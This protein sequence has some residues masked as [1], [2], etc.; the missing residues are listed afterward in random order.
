ME[1]EEIG[2]D[3]DVH[4]ICQKILADEELQKLPLA[5]LQWKL[6]GE[7]EVSTPYA[8]MFPTKA[9]AKETAKKEKINPKNGE[10]STVF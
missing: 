2:Q 5:S 6:N 10:Q 1:I 4:F 7:G 8:K 9:I 3:E